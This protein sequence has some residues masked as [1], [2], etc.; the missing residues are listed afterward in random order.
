MNKIYHFNDI[1]KKV[2]KRRKIG[3]KEYFIYSDMLNRK[4][5]LVWPIDINDSYYSYVEIY[6][7][8]ELI[9]RFPSPKWAY[10]RIMNLPF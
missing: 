8:G 6:K 10:D 9:G 5:F 7:A 4:G 3:T 1:N 2:M